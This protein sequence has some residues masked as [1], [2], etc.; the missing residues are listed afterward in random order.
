MEKLIIF[1]LLSVPVIVLSWR[2]MFSHKNHGFYRFFSWECIVWLLVSNF[3]FWFDNPFGL[4]QIV[5]WILLFA[6]IWYIVTGSLLMI[7]I[8]KPKKSKDRETLFQFEKTTALI[9]T[10]IFGLI[11]HPLYGSLILLTWGIFLKNTTIPLLVVSLV[12][13]LFLYLT[14]LFDEKECIQFFG[15]QYREYMKRTKMFVPFLF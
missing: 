8:G 15:A 7:K 4:W 5:S 14:A 2:S 13:T 10:G 9:D 1:G 6:S 12:S 3:K 11:R